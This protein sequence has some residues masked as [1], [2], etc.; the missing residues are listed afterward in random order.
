MGDGMT[1]EEREAR[2]REVHRVCSVLDPNWYRL[3][4]DAQAAVF[5][6]AAGLGLAA[7]LKAVEATAQASVAAWADAIVARNGAG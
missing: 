1:R 6:T 5:E 4:P 2:E 7:E 3:T